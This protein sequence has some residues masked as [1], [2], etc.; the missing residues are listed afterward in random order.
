MK[1][2]R[3]E[4]RRGRVRGPDGLASM[5]LR[6]LKLLAAI[7]PVKISPRPICATAKAVPMPE[8]RRRSLNMDGR[9]SRAE[10]AS[11]YLT[12]AQRTRA[13]GRL[14]LLWGGWQFSTN[15]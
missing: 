10:K 9:G 6:A 2:K 5:G 4:V 15:D 1:S 12:E 7:G 3:F 8:E 13:V 14:A 11:R